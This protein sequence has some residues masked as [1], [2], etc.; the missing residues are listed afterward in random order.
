MPQPRTKYDIAALAGYGFPVC[1]PLYCPVFAPN[2]T[3]LD[4]AF[5]PTEFASDKTGAALRLS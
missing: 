2:A 3:G 4:A 5:A 1:V